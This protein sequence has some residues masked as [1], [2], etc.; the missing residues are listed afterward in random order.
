MMLRRMLPLVDEVEVHLDRKWLAK[1]LGFTGRAH[2]IHFGFDGLH[3]IQLEPS[4]ELRF[5]A[6]SH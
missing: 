5:A 1:L 2:D 4:R 3:S 6:A